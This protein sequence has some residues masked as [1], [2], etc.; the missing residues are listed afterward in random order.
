MSNE[1]T[2]AVKRKAS[3][4][5][6]T[7]YLRAEADNISD[8]V[9]E[10]RH[11]RLMQ[12]IRG[13]AKESEKSKLAST[14]P[15]SRKSSNRLTRISFVWPSLAVAMMLMLVLVVLINNG[16]ENQGDSNG[17]TNTLVDHSPTNS[18]ST[19]SSPTESSLNGLSSPN[20]SQPLVASVELTQEYQA[21]QADW[22]KISKQ[23][24]SL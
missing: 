13:Y 3:Q 21:I 24:T 22:K 4:L 20:K 17:V 9:S 19:K 14:K 1:N 15:V 18:S 11:A 6:I 2:P 8:H 12:T 10:D 23:L 16:V 5:N 7:E